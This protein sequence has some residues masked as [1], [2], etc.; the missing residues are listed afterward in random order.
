MDR[1]RKAQKQGDRRATKRQKLLHERK[2]KGPS[3]AELSQNARGWAVKATDAC[4]QSTLP[5]DVIL[6]HILPYCPW[7]LSQVCSSFRNMLPRFEFHVARYVSSKFEW[8]GVLPI[9]QGH[10]LALCTPFSDVTQYTAV[11]SLPLKERPEQS[12]RPVFFNEPWYITN[13]FSDTYVWNAEQ[14]RLV[15]V[16]TAY[17]GGHE[18]AYWISSAKND[19]V[20]FFYDTENGKSNSVFDLVTPRDE[21]GTWAEEFANGECFCVEGAKKIYDLMPSPSEP[22]TV[23]FQNLCKHAR[24]EE[25]FPAARDLSYAEKEVVLTTTLKRDD[26]AY[27][28]TLLSFD[29]VNEAFGN[30][31][32]LCT[33]ESF[34]E[35]VPGMAASYV[36]CLFN[37]R[38]GAYSR[39]YEPY[40]KVIRLPES[41]DATMSELLERPEDEQPTKTPL[42]RALAH[43]TLFGRDGVNENKLFMYRSMYRQ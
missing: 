34:Y 29:E 41:Y 7:E 27:G 5:L 8:T 19:Y 39:L 18:G 38:T 40:R 21:N 20:M 36:G 6:H 31:L 4:R 37:V 43:N 15:K 24:K 42:E 11:Y 14:R 1:K 33:E 3:L 30:Q 16:P 26:P 9:L 23:H 12:R 13:Y 28:R 32:R 10:R 25:E 22:R 17:S 2:T 35:I